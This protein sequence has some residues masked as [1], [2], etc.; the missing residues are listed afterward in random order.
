MSGFTLIII[1]ALMHSLWNILLKKSENKYVF[2]YQMHIMNV[3]IFS[4]VYII[5]FRKDLYFDLHTLFISFLAATFFSLYHIFLTAAYSYEDA[6]KVYPVTVASPFFI[7][8]W[9]AIFLNEKVTF[10]GFIGMI[11]IIMG[12][13]Q[14]NGGFLLVKTLSKGI[15][16][17]IL[18][19]FFYSIGSIFDKIGVGTINFTLYVYSLIFFYDYFYF[20]L[21]TKNSFQSHTTF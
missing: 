16:L 12:V 9:A 8:I 6:S 14:I 21:F 2:N 17:A 20:Y 5:F 1:S 3:I 7:L 18:S 15:I 11:F 13:I 10:L 19:M 4:F